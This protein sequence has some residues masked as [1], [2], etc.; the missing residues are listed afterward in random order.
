MAVK[1]LTVTQLT[2]YIE[3]RFRSDPVLDRVTVRGEVSGLWLGDNRAYGG[4]DLKDENC[5]IKCYYPDMHPEDIGLLGQ[6]EKEIIVTGS[7]R[8]YRKTAR[9]QI[10]VEGIEAGEEGDLARAFALLKEKLES[11]GLFDEK[12]KKPIPAFPRKLA[13]VTSDSGAAVQDLLSTITERNSVADIYIC[14]VPVQGDRAPGEIAAMIDELNERMPQL[15][16]MIVGRGGGSAEDLAAFNDE[17]VARSI[18]RS[19]IPVISAVGHETDHSISDMVADKWAITPTKAALYIPDTCELALDIQDK[20]DE[21]ERYIEA[22]IRRLQLRVNVCRGVLLAGEP[23]REQEKRINDIKAG[24]TMDLSACIAGMKDRLAALNSSVRLSMNDH[25]NRAENAAGS[26]LA[27]LQNA[28]PKAIMEK[29]YAAVI[30]TGGRLATGIE[31]L[32][33]GDDVDIRFRD[34]TAAAR[35]TAIR[36][37]EK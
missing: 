26:Q 21:L 16:L 12:Y 31:D 3:K 11:E 17:R 22:Y 30:K 28:N 37:E 29:G 13:I 15:D 6:N 27:V 23:I 20:R 32:A 5:L 35:I 33:P 19:N 7:V 4:F 2:A 9:I 8:A 36:E 10:T 18:F 24:M 25:M 1:P 14:N 34:G